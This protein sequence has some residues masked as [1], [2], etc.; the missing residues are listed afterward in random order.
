[1]P[2]IPEIRSE[3][4]TVQEVGNELVVYDARHQRAHRLNETITTVFRSSDGTRTV[5]DIALLFPAHLNVADRISLV[6]IALRDLSEADLLTVPVAGKEDH[7]HSRRD[8]A[9]ALGLAVPV[10]A[11]ILVPTPVDAASASAVS[12]G[13]TVTP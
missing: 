4:I 8:L 5:E 7:V 1:M 13:I 10:I 3:E 11:S 6:R 12:V 9:A 2:Y